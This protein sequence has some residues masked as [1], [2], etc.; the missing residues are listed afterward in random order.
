MIEGIY[1]G[2]PIIPTQLVAPPICKSS[3]ANGICQL[4]I[5]VTCSF[6]QEHAE[7]L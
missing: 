4:D 2:F 3:I 1:K 6:H 5:F 7:V